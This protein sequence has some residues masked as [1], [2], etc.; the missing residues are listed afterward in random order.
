M[1]TNNEFIE[2]GF[3]NR[4][5]PANA[6]SVKQYM[7]I[8]KNG[9]RCLI[10]RFLNETGVAVKGF[11]FLLI[12]LDSHGQEI[13]RDKVKLKR[14]HIPV[15]ATYATE[16]GVAVLENCSDFIVKVLYVYSGAYRYT[17]VGGKAVAHYDVRGFEEEDPKA[18]ASFA[19]QA[20]SEKKEFSRFFR[21]VA[22]LMLVLIVVAIA[23]TILRARSKFG[24]FDEE[25]AV[26][27]SRTAFH[28][29]ALSI[30]NQRTGE[31]KQC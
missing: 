19:F 31:G 23:V 8:R 1:I 4:P 18:N 9:K 25:S 6:L 29:A 20:K 28:N 15:D 16:K 11:Q 7:L 27:Q 2:K 12:Q 22:F 21:K 14:L 13:A 10:F 24:K 30:D 17:Y 5:Q 3:Y 26:T